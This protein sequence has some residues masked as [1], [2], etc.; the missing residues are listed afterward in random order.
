MYHPFLKTF[1][2][3][4][5]SGS[6]LK[7]SN[8]LYLSPPAIMKQMNGLE[9][10]LGLQLLERTNQGIK[11]TAAG[12][13]IYQDAK[14]F[15]QAADEAV[16][17]ALQ[18]QGT[19]TI[20][21]GSSLLYPGS[22]LMGLWNK[23]ASS[24]PE[25]RLKLVPFEDS[26]EVS[27]TYVVGTKCDL[28][29]GAYNATQNKDDC[30]FMELGSYEFAIAM[31]YAHP[32]ATKKLL[33]PSDLAGQKLLIMK[34]GNS[35]KNDEIRHLLQNNYPHVIL[36]DVPVHYGLEHF[37]RCEESGCLLLTLSGWKN[38]HPSL[39]TIPFA[40]DIRLPYGILYPSHPSLSVSLF[41]D[42]LKKSLEH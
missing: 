2:A 13:S 41:L 23:C 31:S 22:L 42:V 16:I 10:Y 37:N 11:L 35:P 6:F 38:I 34:E 3:V 33:H 27:A 40:V 8:E 24:H 30:L 9:K 29:I 36:E 12:E 39:V 4:A 1:L 21:V 26:E 17:R 18:K 5:D 28:V 25:F 20:R 32:L 14:Q 15:V 19:Y 7:A